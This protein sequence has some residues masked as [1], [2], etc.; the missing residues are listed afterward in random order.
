[1]SGPTR[2]GLKPPRGWGEAPWA[3]RLAEIGRPHAARSVAELK[4]VRAAIRAEGKAKGGRWPAPA[5]LDLLVRAVLATRKAETGGDSLLDASA[6]ERALRWWR[7]RGEAPPARIFDL[8]R[9]CR[10]VAVMEGGV[11][12]EALAQAGHRVPGDLAGIG[13]A[14]EGGERP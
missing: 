2:K 11:P 7:E 14:G 4:A 3:A 8:R 1:M 6:V 13:G 5:A 9:R 12:A 10:L